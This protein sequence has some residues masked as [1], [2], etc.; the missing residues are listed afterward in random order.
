M[1]SS[2]IFPDDGTYRIMFL[3]MQHL[4]QEAQYRTTEFYGLHLRTLFREMITLDTFRTSTVTYKIVDEIVSQGSLYCALDTF[5]NTRDYPAALAFL[6]FWKKYGYDSVDLE[7]II[8]MISYRNYCVGREAWSERFLGCPKRDVYGCKKAE[9]FIREKFQRMDM[10][11]IVRCEEAL[12][13]VLL[14]DISFSVP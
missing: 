8:K 6:Q 2:D 5:I 7:K 1:E 10:D 9:D 4:A 13:R 11:E 14:A 12:T 3:T